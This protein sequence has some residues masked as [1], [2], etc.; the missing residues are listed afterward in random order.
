MLNTL[1]FATGGP[2][3]P[4]NKFTTTLA[5]RAVMKKSQWFVVVVYS[6]LLMFISSYSFV[7]QMNESVPLTDGDIRVAFWIGTGMTFLLCGAFALPD[8]FS[9]KQNEDGE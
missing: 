9:K 1:L 2:P 7:P 4:L 8:I 6:L 3:D 5:K